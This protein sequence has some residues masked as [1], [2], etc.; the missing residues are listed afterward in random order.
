[1]IN[2]INNYYNFHLSHFPFYYKI[3]GKYLEFQYQEK[4]MKLIVLKLLIT[5]QIH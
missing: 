4:I 2:S 3:R 1:M 5:K